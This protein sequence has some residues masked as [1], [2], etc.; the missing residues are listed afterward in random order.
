MGKKKNKKSKK[1]GRARRNK[2]TIYGIFW[3]IIIISVVLLMMFY[4]S[5]DSTQPETQSGEVPWMQIGD[6]DIVTVTEC[7]VATG[8][9]SKYSFHSIGN[10]FLVSDEADAYRVNVKTKN[11]DSVEHKRYIEMFMY[12][13]NNT[14]LYSSGGETFAVLDPNEEQEVTFRYSTEELVSH[15][16][17]ISSINHLIFEITIDW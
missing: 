3:F 12:D 4:F 5:Q 15:I 14:L 8:N 1:E 17:D 10:G 16:G 11:I 6:I 2:N 9:G 7:K 13:S